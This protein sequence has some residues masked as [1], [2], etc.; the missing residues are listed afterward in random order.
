[1]PRVG[2]LYDYFAAA[3]DEQ[4]A[5]TIDLAGGPG[6]AEPFSPEL[7]AAI[8]TGDRAALERLM[9]P[10]VRVSEHGLEV[11]SVKGIDPVVRMGTLEA[12]LTGAVP[13]SPSLAQGSARR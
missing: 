7:D 3:S 11:L 2:V 1:M 8:R 13:R 6:G 9:L 12:L 5:A 10:R 4:A